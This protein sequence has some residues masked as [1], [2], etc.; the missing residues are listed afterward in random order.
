MKNK[1]TRENVKE[2][3]NKEQNEVRSEGRKSRIFI[4]GDTHCPHDI[5]KLKSDF[6]PQGKE[7]TKRYHYYMWGC[8]VCM[9]R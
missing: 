9:G 6:F 5:H 3:E 4:T 7:L 2:K 1:R 8:G